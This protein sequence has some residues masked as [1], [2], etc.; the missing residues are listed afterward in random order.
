MSCN[1]VSYASMKD[2]QF[3][4][5]RMNHSRKMRRQNMGQNSRPYKCH[6][7]QYHLT[8]MSL[9]DIRRLK[10]KRLEVERRLNVI[11][12]ISKRTSIDKVL[13][14]QEKWMTL[15]LNGSKWTLECV[16]NEKIYTI[17]GKPI[18]GVSLSI[19]E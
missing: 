6:C 16:V 8:T 17:K 4:L 12:Q 15:I 13:E 7:G 9:A 19:F 5:H 2:V 14:L 18:N 1:K 10:K 11:K 3:Q